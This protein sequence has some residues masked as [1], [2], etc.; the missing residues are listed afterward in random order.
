MTD[1][2][3]IETVKGFIPPKGCAMRAHETNAVY[4]AANGEAFHCIVYAFRYGFLKG[5]RAEKAAAKREKKRLMERDPDTFSDKL[6]ATPTI[7]GK[8]NSGPR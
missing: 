7:H 5:Q 2:K 1:E 6:S 3:L 8:N 4:E